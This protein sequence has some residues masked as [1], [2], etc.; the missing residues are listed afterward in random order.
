MCAQLDVYLGIGVRVRQEGGRPH[1]RVDVLQRNER[2]EQ[3]REEGGGVEAGTP[4]QGLVV[5]LRSGAH[6]SG[7]LGRWDAPSIRT[8][9]TI[10]DA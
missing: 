1:G 7:D 10:V 9:G 4:T 8:G 5:T 3:R 2:C 6:I